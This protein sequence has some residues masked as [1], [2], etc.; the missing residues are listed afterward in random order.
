MKGDPHLTRMVGF[1]SP[2]L[3]M[4][5]PH[6]IP[7]SAKHIDEENI[8]TA[9]ASTIPCLISFPFAGFYETKNDLS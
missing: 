2:T 4:F 1:R 8:N 5:E 3:T 9:R 7:E 6:V